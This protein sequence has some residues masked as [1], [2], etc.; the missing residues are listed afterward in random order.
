M[1]I[2]QNLYEAIN[3]LKKQKKEFHTNCFFLY[4]KMKT[5]SEQDDA[6]IQVGNNCVVL[7]YGERNFQRL[8]YWASGFSTVFEICHMA[9]ELNR[10]NAPI[11]VDVVGNTAY[12][13]NMDG[14][15]E[16]Q[17]GRKHAILS[18]Y[19]AS[20]LRIMP[21]K[22]VSCE[23][24]LVLPEDVPKIGPLLEENLDPFVSHLPTLS[25]LYE[26]QKKHLLYGC[27]VHGQLIGVECLET[28][29]LKGRYLY[30]LA[31]KKTE[32]RKGYATVL[33]NYTIS[34]VSQCSLWLAWIDDTNK[35]SIF[36]NEK[37]GMTRDGLKELVIIL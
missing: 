3:N 18:R 28:V 13:H 14:E 21:A 34:C 23:C 37:S 30:Q 11:V 4:P 26:L 31:I 19:R 24:S 32:H 6:K 35:G 29:G 7:L 5:L 10:T 1:F 15:F 27:Y 36:L 9:R 20:A 33:K 25:Y 12:I 2:L 16:K 17:K 8:Y 22:K